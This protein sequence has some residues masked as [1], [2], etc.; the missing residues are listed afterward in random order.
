MLLHIGE[1]F[2]SERKMRVTEGLAARKKMTTTQRQLE[3]AQN[4]LATE[5]EKVTSLKAECAVLVD[6]VTELECTEDGHSDSEFVV[7]CG[8]K[9]SSDTKVQL[10]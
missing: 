9:N 3:V 6:E 10:S 7:A 2:E 8:E 4:H 5:R 1:A